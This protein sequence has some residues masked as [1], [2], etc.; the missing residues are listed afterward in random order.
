[1]CAITPDPF[2]AVG[3]GYHDFSQTS[4]DQVRHLLT[5][6]ASLRSPRAARA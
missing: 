5:A 3:I 2:Y 1:V 4:D 6:A